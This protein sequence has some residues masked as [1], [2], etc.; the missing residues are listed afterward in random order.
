[1]ARDAARPGLK[2]MGAGNDS[3][4]RQTI[5]TNIPAGRGRQMT[6][7]TNSFSAEYGGS[8]GSVVNIVT[9]SG[10]NSYH[11]SFALWRPSGPEASLAGF[12]SSNA[13]SGN[14]LT[15]DTLVQGVHQS[16][17]RSA[18]KD[19]RSFFWERSTAARTGVTSNLSPGPR[20]L[21]GPR[22]DW[23]PTCGSTIISRKRT[24]F[25]PRQRRRVLR[26]Q[27]QWH[28]RRQPASHSGPHLPSTHLLRQLGDNAVFSPIWSTAFASSFNS[29]HR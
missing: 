29:L 6:V 22:L 7:L 4:G 12:T 18:R 17:A 19:S 24:N 13:T 11:G 20:K 25:F 2:W 26:H 10:G 15:N 3:W 16:R 23:L 1:M 27:P 8:T 9:K 14:D 5:F 28:R 21:H